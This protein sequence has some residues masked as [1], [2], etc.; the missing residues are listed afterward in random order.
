MAYVRH[1][2]RVLGLAGIVLLPT[3]G[4]GVVAITQGFIQ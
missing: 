3:L 1:S 4:V 2:L